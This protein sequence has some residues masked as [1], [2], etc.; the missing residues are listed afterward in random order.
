[1][2]LWVNAD[3][4][5]KGARD[6]VCRAG[7][8]LGIEVCCV[9]SHG[10]SST[11]D[12]SS[13]TFRQDGLTGREDAAH[14]Y[15]MANASEGDVAVTRGATLG[16]RLVWR[17]LVAID[18]RGEEYTMESA[19]AEAELE[20]LVADVR[21]FAAPSRGPA[22]YD[23]RAKREFAATLDRVLTRLHRP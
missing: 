20:E 4:A 23:A 3:L 17:G 12:A 8:R 1:M 6:I 18:V 13:P 5:P 11:I 21:S 7:E 19:A 9:S 15:V 2:R 16:S 10:V 22:P 14:E